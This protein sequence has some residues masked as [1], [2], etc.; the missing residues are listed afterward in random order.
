[1]I[2]I[3]AFKT[4]NRNLFIILIPILIDLLALAAGL[5]FMPLYEVSES[6]FIIIY[7]IGLPSLSHILDK[8]LLANSFKYLAA[9]Q[10]LPIALILIV[11][12]FLLFNS[13]GQG[14][15]IGLLYKLVE[16]ERVKGHHVLYYARRFWLRFFLLALILLLFQVSVITFLVLFL[17]LIG[18]F[19]GMLLFLFLRIFF[20]YF[21]FSM[22]IHDTNFTKALAKA[23]GYFKQHAVETYMVLPLLFIT[24]GLLSYVLHQFWSLGSIIL[25]IVIYSYLMTGLQIA[26]MMSLK[27]MIDEDVSV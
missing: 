8:P 19:A 12:S 6:P 23:R 15:Y 11:L 2:I 4:L 18:S 1:V 24:A 26:L 25:F 20:I 3:R 16:K 9:F 22:V 5:R 21:E 13:L 10:E 7:E 14:S 27:K 17:N